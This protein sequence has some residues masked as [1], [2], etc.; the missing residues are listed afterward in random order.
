MLNV[1]ILWE[2]KEKVFLRLIVR[3]KVTCMLKMMQ[4]KSL[5]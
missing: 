3:N 4:Q 5:N 2:Q 1:P